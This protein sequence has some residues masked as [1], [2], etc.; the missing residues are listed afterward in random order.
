L[1]HSSL[2]RIHGLH[3]VESLLDQRPE[4]VQRLFLTKARSKTLGHVLRQLAKARRTYRVVSEEEL[5]ALAKSARHEGLVADADP[6]APADD[7]ALF[8]AGQ[9]VVALDQVEN[10]NNLGAICRSC[11]H[12]GAGLIARK[13]PA[14][15]QGAAARVARGGAERVPYRSVDGWGPSFEAARRH[16]YVCWALDGAGERDLFETSVPPRVLWVVGNERDGLSQGARHGADAILR[17]GGTGWVESL[18]ASVA[19]AA[20]LTLDRRAR[21]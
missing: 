10:P 15:L 9:P 4:A 6:R 3:A 14:Q 21:S 18:N 5:R 2:R 13:G 12:F 7:S 20:A 19:A 11:A 8:A 1:A 17:L 16:G